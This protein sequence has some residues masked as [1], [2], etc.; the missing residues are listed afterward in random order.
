MSNIY[1]I[2]YDTLSTLGYPIKEQG[3]YSKDDILP[4][5]FIT[6]QVI[7]SPNNSFADNKPTSITTRVQLAF[8][9]L[10]PVLKQSAN[11]TFKSVMIPA[12]FLRASGRDLPF[13]KDTGHYGYTSDYNF[14]ESEE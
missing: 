11:E 3:S 8:Y 14:Y 12:G 7:D 13:N 1:S 10:K 2:I 5:T 4:E 9:S 6:Y